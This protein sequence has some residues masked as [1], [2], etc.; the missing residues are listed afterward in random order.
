MHAIVNGIRFFVKAHFPETSTHA[1]PR[2]IF[3]SLVPLSP[4]RAVTVAGEPSQRT[5]SANLQGGHP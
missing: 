2:F 5:R 1:Q 3:A 4:E